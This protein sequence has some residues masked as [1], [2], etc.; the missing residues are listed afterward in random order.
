MLTLDQKLKI[1]DLSKT[2]LDCIQADPATFFKKFIT[3][4]EI[5][6][7]HF[8]PKSKSQSKQGKHSGS[9]SPKNF[10]WVASVGK[11]MASIF[12]VC[13]GV[14]MVDFLQKGQTINR[15]Y[16]A[17]EVRQLKEAI[18][19]KRRGKLRSGILLLQDNAPV[20][21]AQVAMATERCSFVLLP[22][23]PYSLDFVPSD[24]YLFPNWNPTFVVATFKV[25]MTPIMLFQSI[26]KFKMQ[27]SSLKG[28]QS[29]N[30]YGLKAL[31]IMETMLNNSTWMMNLLTTLLAMPRTFWSVLIQLLH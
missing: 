26:L 10:K 13:E 11:V 21:T 20:H 14:I 18:N 29:L 30:I 4:N 7:H 1:L 23:A 3:Q 24:F 28:L 25:I 9:L 15:I 19:T 22:H 8:D 27:P 5:W 31:Y 17:S 6:V 2:L 12:W 16:Y